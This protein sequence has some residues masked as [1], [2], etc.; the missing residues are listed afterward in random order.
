[1][2]STII[3][4][5]DWSDVIHLCWPLH[6]WKH[7]DQAL[8]PT[9]HWQL[10]SWTGSSVNHPLGFQRSRKFPPSQ[11]RCSGISGPAV[12]KCSWS[13]TNF[14][15]NSH[16]VQNTGPFGAGVGRVGFGVGKLQGFSPDC[17]EANG[18]PRTLWLCGGGK[19]SCATKLG[20]CTCP[21]DA[22]CM[23]CSSVLSLS[24]FAIF[25][26]HNIYSIIYTVYI[27]IQYNYI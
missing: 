16:R 12:G 21:H 17:Q 15:M 2:V 14:P 26:L 22:P 10:T 7:V 5:Q 20:N 6:V 13:G 3:I 8:Q 27:Y 1:M 11:A 18:P 4:D 19:W 23:L 9:C 25:C 24:T